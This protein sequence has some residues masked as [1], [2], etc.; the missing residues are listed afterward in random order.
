MACL[1]ILPAVAQAQERCRTL[2][3]AGI[4]GGNT[5][6]CPGRYVAIEHGLVGRVDL[7]L[8]EDDVD[9]EVAYDA[10]KQEAL[11]GTPE[12]EVARIQSSI[13]DARAADRSL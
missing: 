2:L 4:V 3:E 5:I 10:L 13:I 1:L 8:F 12:S 6:S 7:P 9:M 11:R